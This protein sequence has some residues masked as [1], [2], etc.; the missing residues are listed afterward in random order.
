MRATPEAELLTAPKQNQHVTLPPL[1]RW[2]PVTGASYFNVQLWRG[3]QKVLSVWPS[4]AHY[5][6]VAVWTYEG[7]K[8]R[9]LPGTYTWY[10]W[11]GIGSRRAARYGALLGSR[12]F[13][14]VKK[15]PPL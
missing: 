4:I 11:P 3:P 15:A 12:S 6:L 10:V 7:R 9:L 14:V 13:I 5:H 8:H 2:A 1:L